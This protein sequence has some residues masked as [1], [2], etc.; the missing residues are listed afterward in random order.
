MCA[1]PLSQHDYK[2]KDFK[3]I[4]IASPDNPA[5]FLIFP[6]TNR[7]CNIDICTQLSMVCM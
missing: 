7:V 2:Y 3:Y 5:S 4:S 6:G 1:A